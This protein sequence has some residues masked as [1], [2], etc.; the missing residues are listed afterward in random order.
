MW[1]ICRRIRI[2][3]KRPYYLRHVRLSARFTVAPT[4]RISVEFDFGGL[5][6]ISAEELQI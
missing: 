5:L 1:L 3:A 2:V 4:G 6:R